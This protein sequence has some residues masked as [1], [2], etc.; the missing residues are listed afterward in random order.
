[1]CHFAV[2]VWGQVETPVVPAHRRIPNSNINNTY[3]ELSSV[4][5][6]IEAVYATRTAREIEAAKF[7]V[8]GEILGV[9]NS[10]IGTFLDPTWWHLYTYSTNSTYIVVV[11]SALQRAPCRKLSRQC[12]AFHR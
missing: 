3:F 10:S 1:M 5:K 12:L 8:H 2:E 7:A 6:R 9:P 11:V 4:K